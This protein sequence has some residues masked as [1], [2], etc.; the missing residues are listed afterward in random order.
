MKTKLI[1]LIPLLAVAVAL[2]ACNSL[3]DELELYQKTTGKIAL[4]CDLNSSLNDVTTRAEGGTQRIYELPQDLVNALTT[5]GKELKDVASL[6][7]TGTANQEGSPAYSNN[8]TSVAAYEAEGKEIEQGTYKAVV[9]IK[10]TLVDGAVP[11]G[12]ATTDKLYFKGEADNIVVKA[13]EEVT[14]NIDM[15]L[16]NSCFTLNVTKNLLDYYE[17]VEFAIHTKKNKFEFTPTAGTDGAWTSDLY[18]V[19][20]DQPLKLSGKAVKQNGT[21]VEFKLN[22]AAVEISEGD[23][24]GSTHYDIT[25]DHSTAGAGIL[26]ITFGDNYTTYASESTVDLNPDADE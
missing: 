5:S 17:S 9:E 19:N 1:R 4:S 13:L 15:T 7:L 24:A 18:M 14:A 10:P 22:A 25:I 3:K 23:I 20:A 6:T 12:K 16:V 2:S 8:W 26:E 11:E 21:E